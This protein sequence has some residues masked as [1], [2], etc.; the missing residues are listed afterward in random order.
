[1]RLC[2]FCTCRDPA[3]STL[4]DPARGHCYQRPTKP[5]ESWA[6]PHKR[7]RPGGRLS[8]TWLTYPRVRDN[9]GKLG[10]IPDRPLIPGMGGGR[11]PRGARGWGCGRLGSCR[12]NGPASLRSV[13]AVRAG[14]RRWALRQEPRPYGAQQARNL[15][16]ARKGDEG[17]L[18]AL[19]GCSGA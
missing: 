17:T 10:I 14:A 8:N 2:A 7:G 19:R 15:H 1:M 4:V 9:P 6:P 5:C 18:S 12:F 13:R 3:N 11:K 16:N